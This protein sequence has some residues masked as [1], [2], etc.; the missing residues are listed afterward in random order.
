MWTKQK[1]HFLSKIHHVVL[2]LTLCCGCSLDHN[3][4]LKTKTLAKLMTVANAFTASG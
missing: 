1:L 3:A 2:T 4:T